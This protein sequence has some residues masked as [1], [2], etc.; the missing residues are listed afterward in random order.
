MGYL[1]VTYDMLYV[2]DIIY[3]FTVLLS[4]IIWCMVAFA[5]MQKLSFLANAI[6]FAIAIVG[7]IFFVCEIGFKGSKLFVCMEEGQISYGTLSHF[8]AALRLLVASVAKASSG[9]WFSFS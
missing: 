1:K 2:I 5:F 3:N 4:G 8:W 9:F 6:L 7:V